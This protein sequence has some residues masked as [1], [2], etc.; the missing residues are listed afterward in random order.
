MNRRRLIIDVLRSGRTLRYGPHRSQ[1]AD[2]HLPPGPGP[3]PV[4][5]V[6]HGGAW[7][8]RY[9][10]IVMR[11]LAADLV[12]RGWAAWN[13]EYRRIG[14]GGGW[15]ETFQDVAAA[16]DH[17]SQVQAPLDLG[18]V[19]VLGHSAGGHLALWAASRERLPAGSPGAPAAGIPVPLRRAI[20]QAGVCDL[21]GAY[22]LWHGGAAQALMGGSPEQVP[23]RYAAGDPIALLPVAAPVLL[24]HGTSD[25]V[26][27][28]QISR[29]YERAARAA[30]AEIEL[31][32]IAGRDGRH[33]GHVDPRGAAWAAV[34]AR[35]PRTVRQ[36]Q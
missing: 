28:V 10:R 30:G 21:A 35:L 12:R 26:V 4:M 13:I 15:P 1:R 3:H 2:L 27:S 31:V 32:E 19:S 17:L 25:E 9:G 22:R 33:R 23:E 36:A 11:P 20:A 34:A 7:A 8:N 5:V 6:I 16:V 24:V 14:G 29:S 18:R